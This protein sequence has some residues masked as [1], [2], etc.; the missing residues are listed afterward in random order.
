MSHAHR[1]RLVHRDLKPGNVLVTAQRQVK[2]LD[3]GVA[4][5]LDPMEGHDGLTTLGA[6][7]PYTPHYAS[8]E[9]VRG[10]AVTAA[11]DV[12]SLGVVLHEMLTGVRPT[13]RGAASAREAA[14]RVLDEEPR[15]PSRLGEREA[16]DPQW[17][18]LRPRLRG[19][20]DNIVLKA[21][22]KAAAERYASVDELADDLRA[23]LERRP[24]RARPATLPYLLLRR[25]QRNRGAV[26]A[27]TLGLFGLGLGLA[28]AVVQERAAMAIGAVGM[29]LGLLLA[30]VQARQA[31]RA[32]DE[33]QSRFDQLRRL[34]HQVLFEYHDLVEPLVGSTP[35]RRRLVQDAITYLESLA[36]AAPRDRGL[37]LEIGTAWR[38]VAKVQRNGFLRPHLGDHAGAMHSLDQA[39]AWLAPLVAE[40][41][42]DDLA[43][44]ELGLVL[45]ARAAIEGEDGDWATARRRQLRA[46]ALHERHCEPD[47][48]DQRHRLEYARAQLRL[49][50]FRIE[51]DWYEPACRL[52]AGAAGVD[53]QLLRRQLRE[54]VLASAELFKLKPFFLSPEFSLV[55]ACVAPILWRLPHYGIDLPKESQAIAR[56]AGNIFPRAGFGA[57]LTGIE[58]NMRAA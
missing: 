35:V 52:D 30:L 22:R 20:L 57:S 10:E 6:V 8:P 53:A 50:M 15:A 11:T 49:A 1:Q 23:H 3:F 46:S 27:G 58:R 21:L 14:Q 34:A 45:S 47:R 54:T 18:S 48:A 4:K 39:E 29:G 37:R 7:R 43:A 33:A 31:A 41:P 44:F 51:R 42:A 19:D 24:V 17:P 12:Y 5:A 56:Y 36:L 26:A 9:Q 2:L 28:A 16:T 32:R 25:V 40:D 13:G 55:D 38:A